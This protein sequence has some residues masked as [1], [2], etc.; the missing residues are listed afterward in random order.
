V[1]T[2][3]KNSLVVVHKDTD[4]GKPAHYMGRW[5]NSH[6]ECGPWSETVI[7]SIGA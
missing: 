1:G 2:S 6:A 5:K 3:T 4:A 7:A